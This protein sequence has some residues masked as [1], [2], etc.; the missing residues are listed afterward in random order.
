MFLE[1]SQNSQENTLKKKLGH[2]LRTS[3]L[4]NTFG[5]LL[6]VVHKWFDHKFPQ[7]L[8]FIKVTTKHFKISSAFSSAFPYSEWVVDF[9]AKIKI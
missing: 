4:Q 8:T 1:I 5:L 9:D 7:K 3:F 6:L 2:S